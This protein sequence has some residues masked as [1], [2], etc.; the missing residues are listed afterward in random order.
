MSN[1]PSTWPLPRSIMGKEI[2][3]KVICWS[4]LI[5][6]LLLLNIALFTIYSVIHFIVLYK[7][8]SKPCGKQCI[9]IRK[10]DT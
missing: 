4:I 3:N 10:V 7:D 2:N 9:L 8:T 1:L 6:R 5:S